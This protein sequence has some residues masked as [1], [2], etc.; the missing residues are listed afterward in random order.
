MLNRLKLAA[1]ILA[2]ILF[3]FNSLSQKTNA[4]S[5]QQAHRAEIVGINASMDERLGADDQPAFVVH[6]VGEVHGSLE[7]CG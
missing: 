1:M 3:T 5:S 7:T 4:G 6:F 2:T